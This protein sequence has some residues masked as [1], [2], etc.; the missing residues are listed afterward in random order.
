MLLINCLIISFCNLKLC[1]KY[2][3][4]DH[5]INNIRL[6]HNLTCVLRVQKTYNSTVRFS[7]YVVMFILFSKPIL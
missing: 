2:K 1:I 7:K 6:T 3:L 5:I 4:I